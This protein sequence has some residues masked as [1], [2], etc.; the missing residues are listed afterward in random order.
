MYRPT[1]ALVRLGSLALVLSGHIQSQT[2]VAVSVSAPPHA[3]S[4][5][6]EAN[7]DGLLTVVVEDEKGNRIQNLSADIPVHTG[8]N[9]IAWDGSSLDGV[10]H[11][12]RYYVRGLFHQQIVPHLQYSIYSPGTPPW[13]K[14]DGTGAW[15]ADHTA[16]ASALFLPEGSAWP[17]H[18]SSPQVLFGAESA[19]AGHALMWTDLDGHKLNGIKIRGWNGGIALAR[20]DGRERNLDHIAYTVYV[21]NPSRDFGKTDPGALQIFILTKTGLTP[22]P[23]VVGGIQMHD[24]FRQLVGLGVQNGLLLLANPAAN[25]IA[26]FDVRHGVQP[27]FAKIT[28]PRLG[29]LAFEPDGHLLVSTDGGIT[30]FTVQN[31]WHSLRLTNP[32]Q[33]IPASALES[34]KQIIE[35]DHE[36]YV[37]DWGHSHQ[38]KVFSA[39]TGK[40]A[41]VIGKPGGPQIGA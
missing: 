15:L 29:A 17:T 26:A 38:V 8:H 9:V 10:A 3:I 37:T 24:A 6:Y 19:E 13:P 40:L 35:S 4:I 2:S 23:K 32:Q 31:D 16:P 14:A 18:S 7:Q 41:R 25:E 39:A 20:D 11:P 27:S 36:I 28:V 5:P 30:R 22:L 33:V 21:V 34:P 1:T 12:G